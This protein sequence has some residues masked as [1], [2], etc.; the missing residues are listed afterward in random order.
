MTPKIRRRWPAEWEPHR[1][2]WLSWPHNRDTWPT[3]LAAVEDAFCEMVRQIAPGEDVE[4]NVGGPERAAHVEARLRGAGVRDL[5]RIHLRDVPT[6]D[7][8]VRDHG[9]IFVFEEAT[10]G[11]G[12]VVLDFIYDAWGGKYPPST[13]TRRSRRAWP[14]SPGCPGARTTSCSKPARSTATVPGRSSRPSPAC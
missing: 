3:R 12:R 9:G 11:D 14:S 8:W 1:A 10:D 13:R 2:T 6:N 4:I 5:S 7:A